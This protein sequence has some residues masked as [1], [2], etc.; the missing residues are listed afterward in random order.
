MVTV[1]RIAVTLVRAAEPHKGFRVDITP[2]RH[3]PFIENGIQEFP[4][5]FDFQDAPYE[6][7]I[8][9]ISH[10]TVQCSIIFPTKFHILQCNVVSRFQPNIESE[11]I[12]SGIGT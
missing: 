5:Y 11:Q 8:I 3:R 2:L 12:P 9:D 1:L 6:A 4:P 7:P 10:S